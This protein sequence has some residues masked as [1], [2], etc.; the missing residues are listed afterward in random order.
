MFIFFPD[1]YYLAYFRRFR[2]NI[3]Y[4]RAGCVHVLYPLTC[5]IPYPDVCQKISADLSLTKN[6][7]TK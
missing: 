5:D 7:S 1:I 3:G 4:V 6:N 2:N